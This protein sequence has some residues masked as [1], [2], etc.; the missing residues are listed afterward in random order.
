[1]RQP[2]ED[3][4]GAHHHVFTG[5]DAYAWNNRQGDRPRLLNERSNAEIRSRVVRAESD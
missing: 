3:R 4:D 1:M 5:D 2:N